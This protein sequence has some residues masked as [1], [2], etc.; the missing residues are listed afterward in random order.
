MRIQFNVGN[1]G[2]DIPKKDK[3]NKTKKSFMSKFGFDLE[4]GIIN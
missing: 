2:D 4:P 3:Y 1:F